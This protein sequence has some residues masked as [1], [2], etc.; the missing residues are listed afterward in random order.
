MAE[1]ALGWLIFTGNVLLG[2]A[3]ALGIACL[4]LLLAVVL[5]V[6]INWL[7]REKMEF[8]VKCTEVRNDGQREINHCEWRRANNELMAS[9]IVLRGL[10]RP[11]MYVVEVQLW[12]RRN[13]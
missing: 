4:L 2:I 9:L 6:I 12:K 13:E 11:G 10:C 8:I 1:H 5:A 3:M 7:D